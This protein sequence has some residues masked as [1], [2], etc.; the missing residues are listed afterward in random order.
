MV[1]T[2]LAPPTCDKC[3]SDSQFR[4]IVSA[5]DGGDVHVYQCTGCE[6]LGFYVVVNDQL[7][8]WP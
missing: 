2:K 6:R 1:A 5:P 7:R 8:P 3:R 4:H